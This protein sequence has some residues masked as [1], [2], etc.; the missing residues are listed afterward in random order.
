[1]IF[2]G[3]TTL[4]FCVLF[5]LL[6]GCHFSGFDPEVHENK[7]APLIRNI[8]RANGVAIAD[9]ESVEKYLY[10]SP[11]VG[12]YYIILPQGK[13]RTIR[14]TDDITALTNVEH[15]WHQ[16]NH[17]LTGFGGI[18]SSTVLNNYDSVPIIDS[19]LIKTDSVV[20]VPILDLR[21]KNRMYVDPSIARLRALYVMFN[22][23][24]DSLLQNGYTKM[25]PVEIMNMSN[26]PFCYDSLCIYIHYRSFIDSTS[27]PLRSWLL[28]YGGNGAPL[29]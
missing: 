28:K 17:V 8:L 7:D 27:D 26:P 9:N 18:I 3:R 14:L 13:S 4:I 16:H 23:Y 22:E 10:Y 15:Y 20:I 25:L 6:P 29:P 21:F 2:H 24:T 11:Y 12:W 5:F 19:L 1:M